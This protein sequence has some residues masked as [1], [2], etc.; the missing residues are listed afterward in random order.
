MIGVVDYGMGNLKSIANALDFLKI[1]YIISRNIEE[2]E[3]CDRYILPGV[4]AFKDAI[5]YIKDNSLDS[6][7]I[8]MTKINK[9]LLGICLG[10]QLLFEKSYEGGETLGLGLILGKVIKLDREMVR[11]P[12]IGWNSIDKNKDDFLVKEIKNKTFMYY[13]HS[14]Y[15]IDYDIND[16]ILYSHY[17]DIKI[18]GLIR[19][20]NIIGA[21][22]HPEKS[23]EDGLKI[24]KAFNNI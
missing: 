24:L 22:F 13:V 19:K 17:G 6:F 4:G 15:A 11:V 23:G 20:G 1:D 10:M 3:S 9:P 12:H 2:L 14:F 8:N 16:L 5:E 21:Q 7:L 18:P